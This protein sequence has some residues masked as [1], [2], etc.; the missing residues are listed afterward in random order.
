M[1]KLFINKTLVFVDETGTSTKMV[2]TRGRCACGRRLVAIYLMPTLEMKKR[3]PVML[4]SRP[5]WAEHDRRQRSAS[6]DALDLQH[7]G[8][9]RMRIGD[10][11][12]YELCEIVQSC[13]SGN[14]VAR[15]V[16]AGRTDALSA[17]PSL[18]MRRR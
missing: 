18:R 15:L 11:R 14:G 1:T 17:W 5:P 8:G 2:R 12:S 3:P 9:R 7:V 13:Q 16:P 10:K 4:G 6:Q